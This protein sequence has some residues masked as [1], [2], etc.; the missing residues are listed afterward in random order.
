MQLT[1]RQNE[2]RQSGTGCSAHIEH[3]CAQS[4]CDALPLQAEALVVEEYTQV[5]HYCMFMRMLIL[6]T[7]LDCSLVIHVFFHCFRQCGDIEM[8]ELSKAFF[9]S[10]SKC[11]TIISILK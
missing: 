6:S 3:T 10:Q 4:S 5:S 1:G 9:T 8:Y 7:K 11:P 2:M